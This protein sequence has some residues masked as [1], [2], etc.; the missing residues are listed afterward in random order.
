MILKVF[1]VVSKNYNQKQS[2]NLQ[3]TVN[4][5]KS[6]ILIKTWYFKHKKALYTTHIDNNLK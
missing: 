2:N 5:K 6:I 4:E 3:M 1:K